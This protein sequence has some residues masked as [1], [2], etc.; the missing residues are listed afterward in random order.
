[1]H[2]RTSA[3]TRLR[4]SKDLTQ[5]AQRDCGEKSEKDYR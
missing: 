3:A 5:R 4:K 2:D 1:L